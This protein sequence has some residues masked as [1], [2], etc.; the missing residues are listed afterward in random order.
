MLLKGKLS[1][2]NKPK[3]SLWV[4]RAKSRTPNI[5]KILEKRVEETLQSRK[6]KDFSFPMFD[7]KSKLIYEQQNDIITTKK[8]WICFFKQF[9]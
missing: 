5:A 6:M 2:E 9:S 7:N 1:V 3:I 8:M 4:Y